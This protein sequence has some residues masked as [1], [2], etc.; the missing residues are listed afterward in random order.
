MKQ[1]LLLTSGLWFIISCG[2]ADNFQTT[3]SRPTAADLRGKTFTAQVA[4][5]IKEGRQI[6]LS[7]RSDTSGQFLFTEASAFQRK[8][9]SWQIVED[10]VLR[11][12]FE[13]NHKGEPGNR[14]DSLLNEPVIW[15]FGIHWNGDRILLTDKGK[16]AMLLN[17]KNGTSS[18]KD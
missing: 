6:E 10:S 3:G 2:S 11:M 8:D 7:F 12:R 14:L 1:L 16:D 15:R 13:Q 5:Q 9:F 18:K 4:E 17:V